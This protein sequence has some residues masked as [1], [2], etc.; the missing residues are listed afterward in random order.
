LRAEAAARKQCLDALL[1]RFVGEGRKAVE[2]RRDEGRIDR[3][4]EERVQVRIRFVQ[5]K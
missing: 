5:S 3:E 2:Q 4:S 1:E